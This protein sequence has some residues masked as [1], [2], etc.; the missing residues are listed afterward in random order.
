MISVEVSK[1]ENETSSNL[2]RRFSRKIQSLNLIKRVRSNRYS[3]RPLSQFKKQKQALK[4]I[5]KKE[6]FQRLYKLGKIKNAR[7]R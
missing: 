4:K 7:S 6:E 2:L 1:K 3:S 5:E